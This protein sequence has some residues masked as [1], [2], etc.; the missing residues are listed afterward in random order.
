MA[1]DVVIAAPDDAALE[2]FCRDGFAVIRNAITETDRSRMLGGAQA[3]LD[4]PITTGRDR[5]ADGKDGFRGVVNL[6]PTAFMPLM[7]NPTVLLTIVAL[8]SPNIQLLTS[9]LISLQSLPLDARRT[10]RTPQRP[11]WHR[12]MYG[13]TDDLGAEHTPRM[14]VKCAY[15]LTDLA[16][17]AGVTMFLPGSHLA[18]TR[19]TV[20]PGSI[21]PNG[22]VTPAV[23]Q[24]D[25]VIF[26]NRTW[27]AAGI[28]TSGRPRIAVMMQYG[29]R[30]LA[31]VDDP[32]TTALERPDLNPVERQLL[33]QPDRAPDGSL[34]KGSGAAAIG[35]WWR[36]ISSP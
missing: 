3:L 14:A 5:G 15:Y 27:H 32:P 18:T 28:N 25:A 26:E 22:A 6:D 23:G 20:P 29:Y 10:I 19:I 16:E 21:D 31:P 11:G 4:S 24:Y 34:A 9:H 13:V 7:T 30:W 2:A 17:N 8:L 35:D 12:D 33:G 36:A 1:A